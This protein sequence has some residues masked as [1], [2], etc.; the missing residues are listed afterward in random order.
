MKMKNMR[1]YAA[2]LVAVVVL[3]VGQVRAAVSFDLYL[4]GLTPMPDGGTA[5]LIVDSAGN[6]FGDFTFA[7]NPALATSRWSTDLDDIAVGI[8]EIGASE[9]GVITGNTGDF[10]LSGGLSTGDK[11]GILWYPNLP[12]SPTLT[13]PGYN[14]QF[15]FYRDNIGGGAFGPE[16]RFEL[17]G[18]GIAVTLYREVG[19]DGY[20]N[21]APGSGIVADK[22]TVIPEPSTVVLVGLSALAVASGLRRRK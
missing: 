4:P 20:P 1:K 22:W 14:Q 16:D 6:G 21:P 17:P 9:T 13:G 18:D 15:G 7:S 3:A 19:V 8:F 12:W 2:A 5:V 10:N 11:V